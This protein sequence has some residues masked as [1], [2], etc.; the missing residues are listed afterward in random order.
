MDRTLER[1]PLDPAIRVETQLA[2]DLVYDNT[3]SEWR[4]NAIRKLLDVARLNQEFTAD[5]VQEAL[6]RDHSVPHDWRALGG[7][8]AEG[9]RLHYCK[10]TALMRKSRQRQCHGRP[11]TVWTSLVFRG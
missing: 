3:S 6:V 4:I 2:M 10:R 7:V 11:K 1:T 9:E 5:D 8:L